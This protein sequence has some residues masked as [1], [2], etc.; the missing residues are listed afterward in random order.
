[1]TWGSLA[2]R[3][4]RVLLFR[5]RLVL[6]PKLRTCDDCG[7]PFLPDEAPNTRFANGRPGAMV[8]VCDECAAL[9]PGQA[10]GDWIAACGPPKPGVVRGTFTD[11]GWMNFEKNAFVNAVTRDEKAIEALLYHQ[12][13]VAPQRLVGGRVCITHREEG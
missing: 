4:L 9:R 8:R 7:M 10:P 5:L 1:M 3:A 13:Y 12:R 11:V 2:R 6:G